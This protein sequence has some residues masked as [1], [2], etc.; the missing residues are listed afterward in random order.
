MFPVSVRVF[1]LFD[2]LLLL[3]EEKDK[4]EDEDEWNCIISFCVEIE[5]DLYYRNVYVKY[6]YG[7]PKY[8]SERVLKPGSLGKRS[9]CLFMAL[10]SSL[11]T[12]CSELKDCLE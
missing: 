1:H 8:G 12:Y 7:S 10:L 9:I 3:G 4:E 2:F 5:R 6:I 11:V